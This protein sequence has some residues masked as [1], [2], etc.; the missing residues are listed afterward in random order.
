MALLLLK[1]HARI[2]GRNY[3]EAYLVETEAKPFFMPVSSSLFTC[4]KGDSLFC[5]FDP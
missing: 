1:G 2:Q 4:T 5:E 3:F